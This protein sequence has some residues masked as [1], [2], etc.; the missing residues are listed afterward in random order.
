MRM[1]ATR[2]A[3]ALAAMLALLVAAGGCGSGVRR[4]HVSGDVSLDGKPIE[5]GNITFTPVTGTAGPATG[6][7]IRNGKYDVAAAVSPLAGGT[8]RV[9]I[10]SLVYRGRS[11]PNPFNPNGPPLKL[12]DNTVPPKYNAESVLK[13]TFPA[14]AK[15]QREDFDLKSNTSLQRGR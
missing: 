4:V 11:V 14:D 3:C 7:E 10:E 6:G 15:E 12:P 2:A 5:E 8:Y 9:Q 13:V 1:T